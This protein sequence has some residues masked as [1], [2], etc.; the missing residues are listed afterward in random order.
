MLDHQIKTPYFSKPCFN[1]SNL[2]EFI[3]VQHNENATMLIKYNLASLEK[4]VL[5][6]NLD[7]ASRPVWGRSGWIVFHSFEWKVWKVKD[8]G[9]GLKQITFAPKDIHPAFNFE[10]NK[11]IFSRS[12]EFTNEEIEEN[13]VL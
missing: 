6:E 4:T 12:Y 13:F 3:C 7:I 8:D 10:G 5:V 2:D 1:P 11:I 9:T